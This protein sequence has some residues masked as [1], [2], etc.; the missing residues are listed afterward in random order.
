M[1]KTSGELGARS[2]SR[3][4]VG[5]G[6]CVGEGIFVNKGHLVAEWVVA[7]QAELFSL[8]VI[9]AETQRRKDAEKKKIPKKSRIRRTRRMR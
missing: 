1:S 9:N 5:E 4:G 8:L 2:V 3:V 7:E 6:I